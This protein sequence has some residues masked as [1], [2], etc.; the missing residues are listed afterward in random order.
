MADKRLYRPNALARLQVRLEDYIEGEDD[1]AQSEGAAASEKL[2]LLQDRRLELRSELARSIVRRGSTSQRGLRKQLSSVN[3]EISSLQST[4]SVTRAYQE[5]EGDLFTVY[6]VFAPMDVDLTLNSFRFA[7]TC[8]LTLPFRD[9]PL[10]SQNIR[11]ALLEVFMGTTTD[12][13]F[14]E[15]GQ[16]LIDQKR[17]RPMFRGYVDSWLTK[18]GS[19]AGDAASVEIQARSLEA[20]LI[21]TRVN[22]LSQAFRVKGNGERI[23]E[24]VNR[25][26]SQIPAVNGRSG[27]DQLRS[28]YFRANPQT[29]PVLSRKELLRTLQT[30]KSRSSAGSVQSA[31]ASAGASAGQAPGIGEPRVAPPIQEMSAW[32]LITRA[33]ALVGVVPTYDPS[34]SLG[35]FQPTGDASTDAG[36]FILLRPPQTLFDNVEGGVD[37]AGGAADG[38]TRLLPDPASTSGEKI[39]SAV[40]L[41]VWGRN[42]LS[43]ETNRNLGRIKAPAVEVR[44]YNPDAPPAERL[45][46]VQYPS[47]R[48]ATRMGGAGEGK[49]LEVEVRNVQGI[50]DKELLRQIAVS[51]YESMGRQE[52]EMTVETRDLASYVDPDGPILPNDEAD[53]LSLRHGMPVRLMV[54]QEVKDGTGDQVTLSPF[55]E[56]QARRRPELRRFL[57]DQ[58]NRYNRH[59]DPQLREDM[60]D[61]LMDRMGRAIQ[62]QNR[63]DIFYTRSINHRWSPVDG[64]GATINLIN[65]ME[66]RGSP[67]NLNR[68]DQAAFAERQVRS[69]PQPSTPQ[70]ARARAL[71]SQGRNP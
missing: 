65:Y 49:S 21:D 14:A 33:C 23:S 5:Q 27:G 70:Q 35:D 60:V 58:Q 62:N 17:V 52:M 3:R 40:R 46:R 59:L 63:T 22:A 34:L 24:Y 16:W 44:S 61:R 19:D 42:I 41:M 66:V 32:D 55:S 8:S 30:A 48:R 56:V 51:I 25:V 50:R 53:L 38:F 37:I 39:Q 71:R 29:E 20:I 28:V 11:A 10:D 47:T 68:D 64:W 43:L 54:A 6:L 7:D 4:E 26:L 36:D 45:L 67:K 9:A 2:S 57:L 18:H 1:Q 31:S 12:E 69:S 13:E 15:R